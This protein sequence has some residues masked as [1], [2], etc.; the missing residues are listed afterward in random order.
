MARLPE[1]GSDDGQW[2]NILNDYLRTSLTDG[3]TLKPITQSLIIDLEADLSS[4]YIKP[5]AG[6][7]EADLTSGVQAKLNASHTPGDGS[8][9]TAMLADGAVTSDKIADGT[10]ANIDISSTA[11]IVKSKLAPLTLTDT[12]VDTISIEKITSLQTVLDG[13]QANLG[14]TAEN[15][16]NKGQSD[17]YASL[18]GSG[19]VPTSQLPVAVDQVEDYPSATNFPALG[20]SGVIYV[21]NDTNKIY[22]WNGISYT[23]ISPSPAT[24]DTVTEGTTNQYYTSQRVDDRIAATTGLAH[25]AGAETFTGLKTFPELIL[26]GIASPT[27]AA[28][29]LAYDTTNQSLTFYNS[30]ANISLQVG[31]EQWMRVINNTAAIITNG[32]PVYITGA[33]SNLPAVTPTLSTTLAASMVIG[34]TT[35]S[36]AV[37]GTGFVT[38][39]GLVRNI[40]T[41]TFA[42][43]AT[44]YVSSATAG[45]MVTT[46]PVP[47]SFTSRIGTVLISSATTGTIIV[48]TNPPVHFSIQPATM[49]LGTVISNMGYRSSGSTYQLSTTG[50]V[51]F[52]GNV[53]YGVATLTAATAT[54]T[55]ASTRY[56]LINATSNNIIITLPATTLSGME[57]EFM[58]TDATANVVTING[59]INGVSGYTLSSQYQGVRI[60][61]TAVSGTFYAIPFGTQ[62]NTS[63]GRLATVSSINALATGITNLYTVPAGKTAVVTDITVRCTAAAAV[64]A[65][66]QLGIGVAAGEDDI[67]AATSLATLVST[68][69]AFR[70][71]T[72]GLSTPAVAGSIIKL[73]IDTGGTG[74]SQTVAVDLIGYLL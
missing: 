54:I 68:G 44:L 7:P 10:I 14:Y 29:K 26:G 27:H 58:R 36:I 64:S 57:Y 28:G 49:D 2:G 33:A 60:I 43:G 73:G 56:Q 4:K 24:T 63:V 39:E 71:N 37:G 34:V 50:G 25:L 40:D 46:P 5:G 72:S 52:G 32:T 67:Q 48:S 51:N 23:E 9:S 16:A 15:S 1:P 47:S 17:G 21:A 19:L 62:P 74:T 53:R 45:A 22:R 6:I 70:M 59:T 66:P 30:N 41:S 12:D 18:D 42:V 20:T 65:G 31:Q 3:G 61:T 35:E 11:A 8:I 38:T 69:Q 55:T 13:K